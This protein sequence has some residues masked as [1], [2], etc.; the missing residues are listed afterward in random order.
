MPRLRQTVLENYRLV[1]DVN[2]FN[3]M[4]RCLKSIVLMSPLSL[5]DIKRYRLLET[6]TRFATLSN[7]A[8]VMSRSGLCK[9]VDKAIVVD[10][11]LLAEMSKLAYT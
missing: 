2:T 1:E 7:F 6:V 3:R 9:F 5:I 10:P 11:N 8:E 4:N